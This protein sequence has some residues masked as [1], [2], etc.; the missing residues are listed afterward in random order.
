M[1]PRGPWAYR[2]VGRRIHRSCTEAPGRASL[3]IVA[4]SEW[5]SAWAFAA[6]CGLLQVAGTASALAKVVWPTE[7]VSAAESSVNYMQQES[8]RL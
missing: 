6:A 7:V 5:A 2:V 4:N 8:D 1:G 3:L